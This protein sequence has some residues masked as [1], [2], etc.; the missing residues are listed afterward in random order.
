M[1]DKSLLDGM[2]TKEQGFPLGGEDVK[3]RLEV[4]GA[5]NQCGSPIYGRKSLWADES[6]VVKRSCLCPVR[7]GPTTIGSE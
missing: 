5:C 2:R 7:L 4:V 3:T 6:P 1:A